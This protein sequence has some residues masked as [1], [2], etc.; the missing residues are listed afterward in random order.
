MKTPLVILAVVAAG[1]CEWKRV[2]YT[3]GIKRPTLSVAGVAGL[4]IEPSTASTSTRTDA[5]ELSYYFPLEW[6]GRSC[7][8]SLCVG[9]H[10]TD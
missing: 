7:P 6:L 4:G 8:A 1:R 5:S 9:H 10:Y 2:L 3:T